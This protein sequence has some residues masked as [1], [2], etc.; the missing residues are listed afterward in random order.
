MKLDVAGSN[1]SVTWNSHLE[2]WIMVWHAWGP[3]NVV[4]SSSP[5]L[6]QWHPG[7]RIVVVSIPHCMCCCKAPLCGKHHHFWRLC[8]G[9]A[10]S[11]IPH[12]TH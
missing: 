12:S 7:V 6:L 9:L 8:S 5:D 10:D 3:P 2:L 1:P 11:L 4:L